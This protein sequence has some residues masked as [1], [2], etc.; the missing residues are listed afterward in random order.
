MSRESGR[1]V[2]TAVSEAEITCRE[3]RN[4]GRQF[5]ESIFWS[6]LDENRSETADL[7]YAVNWKGLYAVGDTQF[8]YG[9]H[10]HSRTL[11]DGRWVRINFLN[12]GV[13]VNGH[14]IPPRTGVLTR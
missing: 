12:Y 2:Q 13:T 11:N 1:H 3:T 9:R 6:S 7:R 8:A 5:R 4:S 14:Y 10:V